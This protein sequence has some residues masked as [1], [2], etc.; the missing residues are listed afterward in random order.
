MR[1]LLGIVFLQ[2]RAAAPLD[3]LDRLGL[4]G[5]RWDKLGFDGLNAGDYPLADLITVEH[6]G[7]LDALEFLL[8]IEQAGVAVTLL[9]R[10]HRT[11]DT[12]CA[13]FGV[14]LPVDVRNEALLWEGD[15]G[16]SLEPLGQLQQ[17]LDVER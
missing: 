16:V 12:R 3:N 11:H 4:D 6:E 17:A 1:L 2:D 14:I 7:E 8:Q 9:A 13:F 10:T 15:F 5:V